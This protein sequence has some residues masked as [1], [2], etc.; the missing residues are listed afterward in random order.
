MNVHASRPH[1]PGYGI[2]PD[3]EGTG[4][5]HWADVEARLAASHDYWVA[6]S[7]PDGRPHVMPVWG[8]WTQT[9][10]W[11][12]SS[13]LSRKIS[14]LRHDARCVITTADAIDPVIVEGEARIVADSPDIQAFLDA[15]NSKYATSYD[16]VFADP[17]VNA[18]VRVEP[19][20]A[21]ALLGSDFTGSPT[22]FTFDTMSTPSGG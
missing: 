19:R 4:L 15:L 6:T 14:N 5:L 12:S 11:F 8:V 9:A 3:D 21:F 17:E 13:L 16:L 22:R 7:W 2:L 1:M 18:T 20:T 10:L